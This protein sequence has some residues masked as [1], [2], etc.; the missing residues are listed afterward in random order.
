MKEV[1][2][3]YT[4][5]CITPW[6]GMSLL[7]N[8]LNQINF[9]GIISDVPCLPQPCSN[10]GYKPYTII[11]SFITSVW[12]GANRFLHTEIT[13]QDHVLS[14]I[15]GWGRTPAQ[16]VYKRYFGKF[17]Q[18]INTEVFNYIYK[19]FFSQLTFDN[20]TIDFDST[21]I[22]RYGEQ[23]GAKRGYNPCKP[24]RASH[25]PLMAFIDD[26]NMV[27]N[28]WLRSGDTYTSGGFIRFLEETVERLRDKKIGLV[29]LDS[30]FYDKQIFDYLEANNLNY[31]VSAKYYQ[32]IQRTIASQKVW[33][34]ITEGVEIAQTEYQSPSWNAPR[35]MIMVRQK[36]SER[37]KA[38]GKQIRLFEGI[39]EYDQY[40][41]SCY[42]TNLRFS[43]A[44]VWR[45]YRRRANAENRIKE[46]KYDFG[47][48]S[49]NMQNFWATETALNFVMIAYN[50]MNLFRI[51]I[52][53]SKTQQRLATLRFRSFAIGAYLVKDGR[54]VILKL[55]LPLKRREWFTG[56]WNES[57]K[58][59]LPVN[60]SNA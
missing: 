2:I 24:G 10:R 25:N 34:K 49:F 8:M 59:T 43:A 19:W 38:G 1:K 29:R 16:D 56:I 32:P 46:L 30:G 14:E 44:E 28:F 20:Y 27:A 51:F 11:E 54:D 9:E 37:P 39:I 52:V 15:F 41:Y 55:A 53:N 31:I 23:E 58:F 13:R 18:S 4:D 5:K 48:D 22:T 17:S 35:R 47:F 26:C 50:L 45:L 12:C 57:K 36:I 33:F 42:I 21:V 40:R 3:Q 60:F 7:K 6:G